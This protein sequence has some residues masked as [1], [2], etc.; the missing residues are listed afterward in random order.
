M[1]QLG[2]CFVIVPVAAAAAAA[3]A[4][5]MCSVFLPSDESKTGGDI[6]I[7]TRKAVGLFNLKKNKLIS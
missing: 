6:F 5:A 4:A 1:V 3:A 2:R 7:S